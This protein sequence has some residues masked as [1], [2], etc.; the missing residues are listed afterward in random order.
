MN[1]CCYQECQ[2]PCQ[3]VCQTT[4]CPPISCPPISCPPISVPEQIYL[5]V[6]G[7]TITIPD[8]VVTPLTSWNATPTVSTTNF[9][10]NATTGQFY[11]PSD[12]IYGITSWLTWT[13]LATGNREIVIQV[14]GTNVSGDTRNGTGAVGTEQNI[15]TIYKCKAGDVI[16]FT[17]WQSSGAPL[18][19][20]YKNVRIAKI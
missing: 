12:G 4:Q 7:G 19:I 11:I 17:V 9:S 2:Y 18:N 5:F 8:S 1:C 10:Y 13:N 16:S 3:Y 14:N 6:E 20:I 15:T